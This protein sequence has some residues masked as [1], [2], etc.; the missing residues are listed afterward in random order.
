MTTPLCSTLLLGAFLTGMTSVVIVGGVSFW[1]LACP[2]GEPERPPLLFKGASGWGTSKT[3]VR[4]EG[5]SY[6][7]Y[8]LYIF[9]IYYII[10]SIYIYIYFVD[11]VIDLIGF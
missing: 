9:F 7:N 11:E 5:E 1:A 10:Y 4:G 3:K 6:E 2:E 8:L